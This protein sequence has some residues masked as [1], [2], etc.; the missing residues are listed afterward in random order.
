MAGTLRGSSYARVNGEWK[1]AAMLL[2]CDHR[3]KRGLRAIYSGL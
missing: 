3:A 2:D 1:A